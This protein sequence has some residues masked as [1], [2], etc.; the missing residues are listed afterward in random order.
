MVQPYA[1]LKVGAANARKSGSRAGCATRRGILR[2]REPQDPLRFSRIGRAGNIIERPGAK[3][4]HVSV[5]IGQMRKYNHGC[6]PG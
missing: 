3:G 1:H 6:A 5:P 4:L 2:K